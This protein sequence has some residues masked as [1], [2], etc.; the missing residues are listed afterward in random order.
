MK[1]LLWKKYCLHGSGKRR[2]TD[3]NR[4]AMSFSASGAGEHETAVKPLHHL[5]CESAQCAKKGC[6]MTNGSLTHW[7]AESPRPPGKQLSLFP[8]LHRLSLGF[9]YAVIETRKP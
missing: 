2:R 9:F 8:Q 3:R 7:K 5:A 1:F 4:I 6:Q